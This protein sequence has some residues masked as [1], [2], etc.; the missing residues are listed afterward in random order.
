MIIGTHGKQFD[1]TKWKVSKGP[2]SP[3][4]GGHTF[5]HRTD[6]FF[7]RGDL[8]RLIGQ[9]PMVESMCST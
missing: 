4:C 9:A 5:L 1:L 8:F 2:V 7:P 3:A 6:P